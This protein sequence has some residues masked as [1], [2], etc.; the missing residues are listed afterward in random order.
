MEGVPEQ[1]LIPMMP[2]ASLGIMIA[3]ILVSVSFL[4]D[5]SGRLFTATVLRIVGS[6]RPSLHR[7]TEAVAR[8]ERISFAGCVILVLFICVIAWPA[9]LTALFLKDGLSAK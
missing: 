3:S 7:F 5:E 8:Y 6:A 2:Y 9:V 1:L 4:H